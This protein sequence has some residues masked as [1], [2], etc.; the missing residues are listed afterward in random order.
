MMSINS[1]S[2]FRIDCKGLVCGVTSVTFPSSV[3]PHLIM[4]GFGVV[5]G[6]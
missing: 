3:D 4:Q 2:A 6:T 5:Q 1:P